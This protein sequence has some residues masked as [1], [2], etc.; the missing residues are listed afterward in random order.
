MWRGLGRRWL[1]A[2]AFVLVVAAMPGRALACGDGAVLFGD[3][4]TH[5]EPD[6]VAE[7]PYASQVPGALHIEPPQ[8]ADAYIYYAGLPYAQADACVTV[9]IDAFHAAGDMGAGLMFWVDGSD[10][11][12]VFMIRPDGGWIAARHVGH[13]WIAFA[14]GMSDAIKQGKGAANEV[15]VR[16]DGKLGEAW[17]NGTKVASFE[18][19]PPR[20]RF[21]FG[22]YAESEVDETDV[23]A[24]RD[25][26]VRRLEAPL[27]ASPAGQPDPG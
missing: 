18:G 27:V 3:D 10:N 9:S 8:N 13:D 5:P 23:W 22:Y 26:T 12:Y 20:G 11:N 1:V 15:E 14:N 6:W 24:F 19:D 21:A 25:M 16:L 17:V 2:L 4:F 7:S